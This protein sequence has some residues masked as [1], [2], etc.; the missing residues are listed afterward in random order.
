M[1]VHFSTLR[2]SKK[3]AYNEYIYE[4]FVPKNINFQIKMEQK[5]NLQYLNQKLNI[6]MLDWKNVYLLKP[7]LV[8]LIPEVYKGKFIYRISG[9]SK[10]I[11][12]SNIKKGLIKKSFSIFLAFHCN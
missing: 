11:S 3:M 9:S 5:I 4:S 2:V 12:Y 10:R 6:G 1:K 8:K 7:C